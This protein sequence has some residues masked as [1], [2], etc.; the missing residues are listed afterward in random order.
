MYILGFIL[1]WLLMFQ[2]FSF[3]VDPASC[4]PETADHDSRDN[5]V[6][7]VQDQGIRLHFSKPILCDF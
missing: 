6:V 3:A 2:F 4:E 5:T 1:L 7:E